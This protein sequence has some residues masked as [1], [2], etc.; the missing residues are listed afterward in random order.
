MRG[1]RIRSNSS[2]RFLCAF[3]SVDE[4]PLPILP[5]LET[6][7]GF[8][9]LDCIGIEGVGLSIDSEG[10][11]SSSRD[12]N[13]VWRSFIFP[14]SCSFAL[15]FIRRSCDLEK[16]LVLGPNFFMKASRLSI[17]FAFFVR[18]T[19]SDIVCS[20]G[21]SSIDILLFMGKSTVAFLAPLSNFIEG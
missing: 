16:C 17:C 19:G 20:T 8:T 10:T 13:A 4:V 2:N 15:R 21:M 9:S 7:L 14:A 11:I 18:T 6:T 3:D 1:C 12:A 5:M